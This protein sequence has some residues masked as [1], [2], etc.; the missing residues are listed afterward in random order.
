MNTLSHKYKNLHLGLF[1]KVDVNPHPK[2]ILLDYVS[3]ETDP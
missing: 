3:L 1:F 2:C